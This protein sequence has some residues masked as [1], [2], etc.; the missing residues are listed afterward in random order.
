MRNA[1]K[2][3]EANRQANVS[4]M[5]TNEISESDDECCEIPEQVSDDEYIPEQKRGKFDFDQAGGLRN[6][7]MPQEFCFPRSGLRSVRPELYTVM[8]KL[9]SELHMSKR[10]IEGSILMIANSL[11]GRTWKPYREN[12][13]PDHDTLPSMSNI[14]ETEPLYEVLAL[15]AIVEEL[16][17][18]GSSATVYAN[19][20]SSRSGVG[21]YVVQSLTINGNQRALPTFGIFT[22]SRESLKELELATLKILS[23]AS[24]HKFSEQ[25]ILN[26]IKFVMTDSTSHNLEVIEAVCDELD[27]DNVPSTLL[28]NIHPLMMFQGKIKE[29]CQDIHDSL[30]KKKISECF[31]VDV[32]F[33]N[34]SFVVKSLKCLSNFINR[35]NSAKPWNRFSHFSNFILPKI[36]H[37]VSLKDHRFNRLNDCALSVLYHM[38][39]I[40]SYLDQFSSIINGITVLDRS[41]LEMEV[42]KPIYAAIS[43]VGI[44]ILKPFHQLIMD[45]D[46]TY[47]TLLCSFPKLHEELLSIEPADMITLNQVFC[48]TSNEHLKDSLPKPE[49][50]SNLMIVAE[51]YKREVCQLIKILLKKFADGFE[52]QKGAIFGF[53]EKKE[54]TTGTVLK[55]SSQDEDMMRVIDQ[56]QIHNLGEER[57]VGFI[58]FELD[59]RGKQNLEAVSRKMVLNKS[60]DL[61]K[62]LTDFRR[63]RKPLAEIKEFKVEWKKKMKIME[64]AGY[65][66]NENKSITVEKTKLEDLEFLQ[67]QSLPG[68][69]TTSEKVTEFMESEPESTEKNNRMYKEIRFQRNSSQALKNNAA[70]FRLKRNGKNLETSEY[71]SN[72]VMYLDQSRNITNL[73]MD[74]LRNVLTGLSHINYETIEN[75]NEVVSDVSECLRN[76]AIPTED[77]SLPS[78]ECGEHVACFWFDD[79]E[80]KYNW[81]LGV[82]EGMKDRKVRVSH[83]KKSDKKGLNWL[84]PDEADI[85]DADPDQIFVRNIQVKYSL[86]AMIRCVISNQTLDNILECFNKIH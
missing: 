17:Q 75:E 24:L 9:A 78:Y 8:F 39:D 46:T 64:E 54:S 63:F 21:S 34:E 43:L 31:L 58:N 23:A 80:G 68:P 85:H 13:I 79:V 73:T 81:Y 3:R 26:H 51:E 12:E 29:L 1:E 32:E 76:L 10:Q 82:I 45:K 44:H 56:V 59:I 38:D 22:E 14:R 53:G 61:T 4:K 71:A 40:A 62:N 65:S 11:F 74:D 19:D 50:T 67:K 83:M 15:N 6:D 7:N 36:N 72:L 42:L 33:R 84:F 86:T 69:L 37:S 16:M 48:F 47:S 66:K 28:C 35:E 70:V 55:I 60:A 52:L 57:S 25:D 30:G 5:T 49:L 18:D 2:K 27:V 77:A 20:G 41:F